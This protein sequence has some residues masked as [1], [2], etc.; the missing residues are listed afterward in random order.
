MPLLLAILAALGSILACL[1]S[2]VYPFELFVHFRAHFFVLDLI[3]AA[4][5][6]RT[7]RELV[8]L[9]IAAAFLCGNG[10]HE[11][12]FAEAPPVANDKPGL[13]IYSA[14]VYIGNDRPEDLLERIEASRADIIALSELTPS[15]AERI[16]ALTK[17][18]PYTIGLPPPSPSGPVILSKLPFATSKLSADP[19][20]AEA[21]VVRDSKRLKIVNLPSAPPIAP[22]SLA[23]R[24]RA[25]EVVSASIR[26]AH[27]PAVVVGDL[28]A[29]PWSNAIAS[30]SEAAGLHDPRRGIG[31]LPTWPSWL[32]I[33]R[34][35][36]DYCL[37]SRQIAVRTLVTD[38]LP[39]SDHL[40]LVCE[41]VLSDRPS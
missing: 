26:D 22:S 31:L 41:V 9:P 1:D 12:Y 35:P 28:N 34:I 24:D 17:S 3:S 25:L 30:F 20:Y 21:D 36:I 2:S 13:R 6:F 29:T 16:A 10:L 38:A 39:G 23:R 33:G 4:I 18:F 27:V 40:A 7:R 11:M 15:M 32:P 37:V 8:L 14:N 19:P 5:L